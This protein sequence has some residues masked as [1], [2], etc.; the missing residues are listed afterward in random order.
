MKIFITGIAGFIGSSLAKVLIDQGHSIYGIDNLFSGYAS[1]LNEH[2]KWAK[3]DIRYLSE[4]DMLVE[5]YDIIIHLA[6]QTSGEKSFN[7]QEYDMDTNLK[8]TFNVF[9]FAIKCNAKL[10]I[11]MSSMSVYGN[12]PHNVIVDENYSPLPVSLYGTTKLAAENMLR[13]LSKHN[14]LPVVSFR[15]FN[16][17][18]EGQDLN[19]LRQGMIS[20][21]LAY[22]LHHDKVVVKG[23][24]DRVR[25][26]LYIDDITSAFIAVINS[27]KWQ[28]N[29]YNLCSS[30][31]LSVKTILSTI[32][33]ISKI[34]KDIIQFGE[35]PGDI[36]G[37]AGD[38]SKFKEDMNWTPKFSF[39]QGLERMIMHYKEEK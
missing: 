17:Y 1:N 14:S 15:L 8:G 13:V 3:G 32:K 31:A 25:D 2:I 4:L 16:A 10:M 23:S 38:N 26:F 7:F 39:E 24:F 34:D 5:N 30:K 27:K 11:N 35:T 36:Q 21:Y 18:G 6:A 22:F 37:F 9:K 28:T 20:I 12:V 33:T 19:E 29:I